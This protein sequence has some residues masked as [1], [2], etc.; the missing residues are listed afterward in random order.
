M[1]KM[2][3]GMLAALSEKLLFTPLI[4]R[5]FETDLT[6]HG[7]GDT[8]DIKI[9]GA[10]VA[11]DFDH[12][13]GIELQDMAETSTSVK[14]D[15]IKDVSF[16]L[17]DTEFRQDVTS[18]QTQFLDP[19]GTALAEQVN[20]DILAKLIAEATKEVGTGSVDARPYSYQTPRVLI[21]AKAQLGQARAPLANRSAVIGSD[22]AAYWQGTDLLIRADQRGDTVGLREATL[23][24]LAGFDVYES[25]DIVQPA[26]GGT[27]G[28][29]STEVGV[30]FHKQ[31]IAGAFTSLE[32]AASAESATASANGL[33]IRLTR[34][35][36]IIHKKSIM[37]ADILYGLNAIRPEW[38]TL[39]KGADN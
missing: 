10:F 24:R 7:Q 12:E 38:I 22:T 16:E 11:K 19:A 35:Y 26:A 6:G 32:S 21:D 36:D 37:S 13:T 28:T 2:A 23:G 25:V 1:K 33:S 31:A 15:T 14:L 4:S 30:A 9:P 29:P 34:Q 27:E 3:T 18:L 20:A 17:T 5:D 39:I 8:V